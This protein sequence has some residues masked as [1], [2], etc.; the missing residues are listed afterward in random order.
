MAAGA[1]VL[2]TATDG[3]LEVITEGETG[4]LVSIGDVPALAS[5]LLRLLT[6]PAERNRISVAAQKTAA[7][8]FDVERMIDE[9]EQI[10]KSVVEN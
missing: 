9:T 6:Q 2:A 10:Y 5:N 1:P 8:R 3:A 7:E 4:F